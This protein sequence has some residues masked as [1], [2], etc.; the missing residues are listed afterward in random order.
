MKTTNGQAEVKP[1][2]VGEPS[3]DNAGGN[4][5][6][7]RSK[8]DQ[9]CVETRRRVCI[10]CG[11][12][13]PSHKYSNAKYCS[14]RCRSAYV[15][16]RHAVRT[17]RIAKPGVGSGGN[18]EGENNHQYKTGIG[19]YSQRAFEHY[20]RKCN[21]CDSTELLLVHHRDED[22][23]NNDL[24]NL[25]VLCKGCHQEHHCIRDETTGRYI[26]G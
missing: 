26:K 11:G 14:D 5:E 4:P 2:K 1:V 6:P 21:R 22:R 16:Y 9:A 25:E 15:S 8:Y 23:T 24:S 12:E 20:G 13:I 3:A 19:T 7:S 17:G 10:K 18:Q